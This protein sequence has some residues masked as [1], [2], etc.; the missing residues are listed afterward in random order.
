M[1]TRTLNLEKHLE[2]EIYDKSRVEMGQKEGATGQNTEHWSSRYHATFWYLRWENLKLR[3]SW[4]L[5]TTFDYLYQWIAYVF[6]WKGTQYSCAKILKEK[7][8]ISQ[9]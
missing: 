8:V 6:E 3:L 2:N 4:E 9:W 5:N 1:N 7:L